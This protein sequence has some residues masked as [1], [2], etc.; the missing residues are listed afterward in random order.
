MSDSYSMSELSVSVRYGC[1][2]NGARLKCGPPRQVGARLIFVFRSIEPSRVF[3]T[4]TSSRRQD[5]T[6]QGIPRHLIP[7]HAGAAHFEPVA[8]KVW[9]IDCKA[10]R[11]FL[12]NRGMHVS[13]SQKLMCLNSDSAFSVLVF[14]SA[15]SRCLPPIV[16]RHARELLGLLGGP[17]KSP[18]VVQLPNAESPLPWMWGQCWLLCS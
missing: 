3:I 14:P 8:H 18:S 10:C 15:P 1:T 13:W 16:R 5:P 7:L 9:I 11:T 17:I 4:E 12:T 2:R 6:N